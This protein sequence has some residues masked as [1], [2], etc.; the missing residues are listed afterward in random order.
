M[1]DVWGYGGGSEWG[2]HNAE[3]TLMPGCGLANGR[4]ALAEGATVLSSAEGA[5]EGA[6]EEKLQKP[7]VTTLRPKPTL[8]LG[9]ATTGTW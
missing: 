7:M 8:A 9:G 4:D 1:H 3:I 6:T 5:A 2:A